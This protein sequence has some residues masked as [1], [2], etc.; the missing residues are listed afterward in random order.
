MSDPFGTSGISVTIK[1]D[2]PGGKFNDP[3]SP[4]TWIVFHGTVTSVREQIIEAFAMDE[5][6]GMLSLNDLQ[7]EATKI[8]KAV[9]AVTKDLG[10]KVLSDG[11]DAPKPAAKKAAPPKAKSAAAKKADKAEGEAGSTETG[12]VFDQAQNEP[13]T[14]EQEDQPEADPILTAL[15]GCKTV[16]DVQQVWAENQ[17]AFSENRDYMTAYKQRGKALS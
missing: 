5:S 11:K 14:E 1:G 2:E 10:G 3:K 16:N 8:F 12:D 7:A 13:A 4:G 15:E 6:A 9:N 17:S